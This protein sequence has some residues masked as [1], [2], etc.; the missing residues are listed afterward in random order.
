MDGLVDG[1]MGLGRVEGEGLGVDGV[2]VIG[3][4]RAGSGTGGL[5]LA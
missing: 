1:Y 2:K 4:D 3:R 5:S